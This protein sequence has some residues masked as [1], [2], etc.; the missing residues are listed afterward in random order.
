MTR[1][2]VVK[3]LNPSPS[4]KLHQ[5]GYFE[6]GPG[7]SGL[8]ARKLVP[9]LLRG[10]CWDFPLI[11]A[12]SLQGLREGTVSLP[13]YHRPARD[14]QARVAWTAPG[15]ELRLF[16][17]R[18]PLGRRAESSVLAPLQARGRVW[19]LCFCSTSIWQRFT[20]PL[21]PGGKC[22][23]RTVSSG[24]DHLIDHPDQKTFAQDKC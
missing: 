15:R 23:V 9:Q 4:R 22:L 1:A 17:P 13:W 8:Q 2:A 21:P 5:V 24:A 3:T 12:A 19:A 16:E 20:W 6:M 11:P 10:R 7:A 14:L 18:G